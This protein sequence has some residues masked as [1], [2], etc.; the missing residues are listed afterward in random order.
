MGQS[1]LASNLVRI[2]GE[3]G[4]TDAGLSKKAGRHPSTV[5]NITSGRSKH[6]RH[7]TVRDLARALGVTEQELT[8]AP[9]TAGIDLIGNARDDGKIKRTRLQVLSVDDLDVPVAGRYEAVLFRGESAG[10]FIDGDLLFFRRPRGK[11]TLAEAFYRTS[12]VQTSCGQLLIALVMPGKKAGVV[13]LH[14]IGRDG[15]VI[16]DRCRWATP[17]AWIRCGGF[18]ATAAE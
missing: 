1:Q 9:R 17:I 5:Y 10:R 14:P 2:I 16:S 18:D 15:K 7:D 6:P 4:L 12:V 11:A 3:R 8:S 13:E